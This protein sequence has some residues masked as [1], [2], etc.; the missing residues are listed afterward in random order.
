[1]KHDSKTPAELSQSPY[2]AEYQDMS[3]AD[4]ATEMKSLADERK[5]LEEI[6]ADVYKRWDY[7][8]K[9]HIPTKLEDA[10]L[11]KCTVDGV[12]TISVRY[13]MFAS[14]VDTVGLADW[15]RSNDAGD[16][17]KPTVNGS[18]L[19]SFLKERMSNGEELPDE[20]VRITPYEFAT[21][22][23]A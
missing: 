15:L 17:I 5:R 12:G 7:L 3:L 22:T 23:K 20:F 13:D 10:G 4:A 2:A 1:M 21:I 8:R 18:T 6:A 11:S 9:V 14:T 16:L 19:K